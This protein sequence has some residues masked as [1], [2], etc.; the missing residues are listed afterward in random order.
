MYVKV[1]VDCPYLKRQQTRVE[2]IDDIYEAM[3]AE[4]W[5]H[6]VSNIGIPESILIGGFNPRYAFTMRENGVR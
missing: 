1:W 5:W 4:L 2:W 3:A 6:I